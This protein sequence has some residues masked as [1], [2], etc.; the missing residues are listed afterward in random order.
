MPIADTRPAAN[1]L[2]I[3]GVTCTTFDPATTIL[4]SLRIAIVGLVPNENIGTSTRPVMPKVES[5]VPFARN[6]TTR[7]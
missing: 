7:V 1:A 6:L 4:S 3:A 5:T 2:T